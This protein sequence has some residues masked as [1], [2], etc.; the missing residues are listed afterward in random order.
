[1]LTSEFMLKEFRTEE[2]DYLFCGKTNQ[3]FRINRVMLDIIPLYRD[4]SL[5]EIQRQL[6]G[7][8]PLRE[9]ADSYTII[10]RL[11]RERGFFRPGG[12][13]VRVEPVAEEQIRADLERDI[14]QLCLEV[15]EGC[16][17]RCHYCAYSGGYEHVRQHGS[18][19]MSPDIAQAGIDFLFQKNR[20]CQKPFSISF[21]G[22]EPLTQLPLIEFCIQYARSLAWSHPEALSFNLTTN[23]LLLDEETIRFLS[24]HQVSLLL[25]LDGP[26]EDHDAHRL[27][28]NGCGTFDKVMEN[29][30][31]LKEIA[32]E[33]QRL[34]VS[35]VITPTSDLLR[36]ND[37]FVRHQ[38][39][40]QRV[41]PSSV[42][43]GHQ[44]F[45]QDYPGDPERQRSQYRALYRQYVEAHLDGDSRP[46]AG[47]PELA[48]IR[49]LFE[50]DF[51]RIYQRKL[52]AQAPDVLNIGATCRPGKRKLFVDVQGRFHVC[53]RV[54]NT[55]PIGDVWN[56][57]DLPRIQQLLDEYVTLMN[58]PEC[59]GCWAVHFCPACFANMATE[60]HLSWERTRSLCES[61]RHT[62]AETLQTYCAILDKNPQAFDYMQA[63]ED[64]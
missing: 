45:F 26:A 32:P 31:K 1:M 41:S 3:V 24:G 10:D 18:R 2:H 47:R 46:P 64:A 58:R 17:L 52:L 59:L 50:R 8:F 62:L 4:H 56:G 42:S 63:Y 5:E 34:G 6:A 23:G 39:V 35:C 43:A 19:S 55:C 54:V 57:Y 29:V 14:E 11:A 13:Q 61:T 7:R 49:S 12:L 48:F 33:R 38:D 21:Y 30:L 40:F 60:G 9:V 37:F 53:E 27:F 28:A 44:T 25:S 36:L 51:I 20:E 16:N 22:G 15:T